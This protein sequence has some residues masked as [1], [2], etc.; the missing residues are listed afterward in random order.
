MPRKKSEKKIKIRVGRVGRV[1]SPR[2]VGSGK[3]SAPKQ[4][5]NVYIS[6]SSYQVPSYATPIRSA[7]VSEPP[8]VSPQQPSIFQPVFPQQQFQQSQYP[9]T[10]GAEP[11][12]PRQ[13]AVPVPKSSSQQFLER[14]N[15]QR[16]IEESQ[17][18]EPQIAEP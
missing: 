4:T 8:V 6:P 15:L 18:P 1:A 7:T 9:F 13:E 16:E 12:S 11:V 14:L 17:K 3:K 2:A 10:I 5:V